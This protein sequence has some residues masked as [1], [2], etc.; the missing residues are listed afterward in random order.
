[1]DNK[2]LLHSTPKIMLNMSWARTTLANRQFKHSPNNSPRGAADWHRIRLLH[3]HLM[4]MVT[5]SSP[6]PYS[7]THHWV[8]YYSRKARFK[9]PVGTC[10]NW[11]SKI[12]MWALQKTRKRVSSHCL[13]ISYCTSVKKINYCNRFLIEEHLGSWQKFWQTIHQNYFFN[14]HQDSS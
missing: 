5:G 3:I 14:Y 9:F 6:R 4:V 7:N 10:I 11:D 13:R 8:R 12:T 2:R 1:M